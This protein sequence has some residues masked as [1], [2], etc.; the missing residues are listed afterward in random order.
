[1][2]PTAQIDIDCRA[3]NVSSTTCVGHVGGS[4]AAAGEA[5]LSTFSMGERRLPVLVIAGHG[6]PHGSGQLATAGSKEG[7]GTAGYVDIP[8]VLLRTGSTIESDTAR[9]KSGTKVDTVGP[10]C[11]GEGTIVGL[12]AGTTSQT[13]RGVAQ[14]LVEVPI[15]NKRNGGGWG[16]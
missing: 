5:V 15:K 3:T 14:V 16:V 1:M 2:V 8:V 6:D 9:E 13:L 4:V 10:I 7:V 11:T 12:R